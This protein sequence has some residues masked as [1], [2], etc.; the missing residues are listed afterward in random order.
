MLQ[1]LHSQGAREER[2]TIET[3]DWKQNL[4]YKL[5]APIE[6]GVNSLEMLPVQL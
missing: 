4:K 5:T 6:L 1:F 2:R 3:S